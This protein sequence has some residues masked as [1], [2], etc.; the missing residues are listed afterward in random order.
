MQNKPDEQKSKIDFLFDVIK[1]YDH[2][3]AT[4]NFKIGLLMSFLV[5]ILV[6]V[7]LKIYGAYGVTTGCEFSRIA[8]LLVVLGVVVTDFVAVIYVLKAVFPNTSS[9]KNYVSLIFFGDVATFDGGAASF[10]EEIVRADESRL[11]K[12][13]SYQVY[14]VAYITS[15]KFKDIQI[16]INWIRWGMLPMLFC[17]IVIMLLS[18]GGS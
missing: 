3:I 15:Q 8:F 9:D 6:G 4:S 7:I 14:S 17:L 1:R 18:Q 16:A 12:D 11:L 10:Y 13:I 5:V 2:Y